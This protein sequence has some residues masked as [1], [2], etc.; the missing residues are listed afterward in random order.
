MINLLFICLFLSSV[1]QTVLAGHGEQEYD[2]EHGNSILTGASSPVRMLTECTTYTRLSMEIMQEPLRKCLWNLIPLLEFCALVGCHYHH[3]D[4]KGEIL[5]MASS[6]EP[7]PSADFLH[8]SMFTSPALPAK[9]LH[10]VIVTSSELL[11][12]MCQSTIF[13]RMINS[14]TR[15]LSYDF[16]F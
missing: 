3:S 4:L 7:R 11:G 2:P 6:R 5:M 16:C 14:L 9:I 1:I 15:K 13:A 10:D 12:L 8:D